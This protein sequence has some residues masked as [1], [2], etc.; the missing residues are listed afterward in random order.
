MVEHSLVGSDRITGGLFRSEETL[1]YVGHGYV[2]PEAAE[3]QE[4]RRTERITTY[5]LINSDQAPSLRDG[6]FYRIPKALVEMIFDGSKLYA[7]K[8]A[9]GSRQKKKAP[10][11]S[12]E[13]DNTKRSLPTPAKVRGGFTAT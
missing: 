9:Y 11:G 8:K 3:A 12:P 6:R 2:G 10:K 7:S 5:S 1:L 13:T 4:E